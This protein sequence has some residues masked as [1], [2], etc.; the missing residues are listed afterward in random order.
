MLSPRGR[1]MS[2]RI[3]AR[4]L[5]LESDEWSEL[6]RR[7]RLSGKESDILRGVLVDC[8]DHDIA[9]GM[10]ISVHTLRTHVAR[11]HLKLGVVD[12]VQLVCAVFQQLLH[13]LEDPECRTARQARI[14]RRFTGTG[15]G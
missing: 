9:A 2:A 10:G 13:M 11:L 6:C 3:A 14:Q 1:K 8:K 7:L 12:R 15:N 5:W 4:G